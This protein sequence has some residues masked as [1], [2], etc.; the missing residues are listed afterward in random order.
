[1]GI[2]MGKGMD[3]DVDVGVSM[4]WTCAWVG[5]VFART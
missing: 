1:M 2:E 4:A 5:V 3:V